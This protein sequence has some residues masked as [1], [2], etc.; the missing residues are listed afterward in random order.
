MP[1]SGRHGKRVIN[2]NVI[3]ILSHTKIEVII[4]SAYQHVAF[5]KSEVN[6][7]TV[8]M[9]MEVDNN[10]FKSQ[11]FEA[12]KTGKS[13][14]CKRKQTNDVR[15]TLA[16][17]GKRRVFVI[18][19]GFDLD[20]GLD[21]TYQ[22]FCKGH[23]KNSDLNICARS[24]MFQYLKDRFGLHKQWFNLED[25]I[26][27]YVKTKT[28]ISHSDVKADIEYF[29]YLRYCLSINITIKGWVTPWNETVEYIENN[30]DL[31]NIKNPI[32]LFVKK[33]SMAYRVLESIALHP[34]VFDKIISFNYSNLDCL[35]QR[36]VANVYG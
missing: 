33:E 16:E 23:F 21:T 5:P 3:E 26:C 25:E 4:I 20:L 36:T 32:Q 24:E 12:I 7:Y 31:N 28:S 35:L 10:I 18:G 11:I 1:G 14:F 17:N 34:F 29:E 13:L 15:S 2:D 6:L 9:K 27:N 30:P 22:S 19:N 8:S